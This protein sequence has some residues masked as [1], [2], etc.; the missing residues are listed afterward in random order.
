LE[1]KKMS[2][3]PKPVDSLTYEQAVA[4]METIIQQMEGSQ[5]D[6]EGSL[7]LFERGQAL[8]ARCSTLLSQAELKVRQLT[9]QEIA[10]LQ[11]E[12]QG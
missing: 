6:L 7:A 4:E 2:D 1:R 12:D 8:A 11:E 9:G 10:S 5:L 3:E